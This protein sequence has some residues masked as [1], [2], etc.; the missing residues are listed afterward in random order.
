MAEIARDFFVYGVN[1]LA[2]AAGASAT[3]SINIQADSDFVAQKLA[4]RADVAA[5]GQTYSTR[6]IPLC[7][8]IITDTGSGRQLMN[9]AINLTDFFGTGESPFILPQPKVFR[10]NSL[11]SVTVA[12][13]DA[14]QTYNLRLSFIGVKSFQG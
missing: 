6:V 10:A 2:L 1:F 8:V 12:N 4:Y 7:A 14:A 13:Y 3:N 5:A 9:Q 11:I